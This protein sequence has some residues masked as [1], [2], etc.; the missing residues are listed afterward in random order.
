MMR[1]Q[2]PFLLNF[3]LFA[4]ATLSTNIYCTFKFKY[5][6]KR[7]LKARV[8][9]LKKLNLIYYPMFTHSHTLFNY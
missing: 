1:F 4:L 6:I 9:S 8:F 3:E 7:Q 5:Q 2:N